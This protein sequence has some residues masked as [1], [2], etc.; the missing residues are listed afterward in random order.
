MSAQYTPTQ[1]EVKELRRALYDARRLID[2]LQD[3]IQDMQIDL[4][5]A[6]PRFGQPIR[7]AVSNPGSSKPISV[8]GISYSSV[9]AAADHYGIT[10]QAMAKRLRKGV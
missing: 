4:C 3:Q 7:Q 10:R 6:Q 5:L 2:S 8:D 1:E 9:Q